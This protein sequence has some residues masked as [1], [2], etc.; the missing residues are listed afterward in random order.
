MEE[1]FGGMGSFNDY[2]ITAQHG[3]VISRRQELVVNRDL[4]SLRHQLALAIR[5]EKEKLE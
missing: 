2:V 4:N 5:E 1:L 3:D